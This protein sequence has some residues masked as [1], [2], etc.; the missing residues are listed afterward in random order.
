MNAPVLRV[1]DPRDGL[2]HLWDTTGVDNLEA[3]LAQGSVTLSRCDYPNA[4][5]SAHRFTKDPVSC[6]HCL[7]SDA[8]R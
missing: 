2:V 5:F 1:H 4:G 8:E 6:F 7:M 3:L